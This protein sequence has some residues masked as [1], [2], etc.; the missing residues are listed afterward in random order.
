MPTDA[1]MERWK[2]KQIQAAIDRGVN[3]LDAISGMKDFIASVP[4]GVDPRGY[5]R[6][7]SSLEQDLTSKAIA[8]DLRSAWYGNEDVPPRFKR[9]LDSRGMV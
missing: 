6:P 3:P 8:D 9:L 1:E 2:T 5:V 4:L 7:A